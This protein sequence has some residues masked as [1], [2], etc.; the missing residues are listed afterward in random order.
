MKFIITH[1]DDPDPCSVT[2][3]HR[4]WSTLTCQVCHQD[5]KKRDWRYVST[6]KP[7]ETLRIPL[8]PMESPSEGVAMDYRHEIHDYLVEK[9]EREE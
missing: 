5:V 2:V 6:G 4:F 8:D 3:F 9:G 1:G 7:L